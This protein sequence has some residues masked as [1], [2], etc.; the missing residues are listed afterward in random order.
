MKYFLRGAQYTV[1]VCMG[2]SADLFA[3]NICTTQGSVEAVFGSINH[4]S[5]NET[6][7]E[8]LGAMRSGWKDNDPKR[9]IFP[10]R[11]VVLNVRRALLGSRYSISVVEG[12]GLRKIRS[13]L[14]SK[15]ECSLSC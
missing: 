15:E 8:E 11:A 5:I 9:K 3:L 13:L 1:L 10:F 7:N 4:R 2:Q 6:Q 12:L 14:I